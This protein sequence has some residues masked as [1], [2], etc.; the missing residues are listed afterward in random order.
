MNQSIIWRS[1]AVGVVP[2][3]GILT[4]KV[5]VA[6]DPKTEAP[7]ILTA[8]GRKTLILQNVSESGTEVTIEN[9]TNKNVPYVMVIVSKEALTIPS[10]SWVERIRL[11]IRKLR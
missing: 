9:P 2:P 7:L 1:P 8:N 11:L 4:V 5:Q 3:K 10:M 6:F